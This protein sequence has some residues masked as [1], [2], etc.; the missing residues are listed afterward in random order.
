MYHFLAQYYRLNNQ[1]IWRLVSK[2]N[3][4]MSKDLRKHHQ[5]IPLLIFYLEKFLFRVYYNLATFPNTNYLPI[6]VKGTLLHGAG[7][8]KICVAKWRRADSPKPPWDKEREENGGKREGERD[9]ILSEVKDDP[10]SHNRGSPWSRLR[11]RSPAFSISCHGSSGAG[12]TEFIR[13][14]ILLPDM[15]NDMLSPRR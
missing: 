9:V 6:N 13:A 2:L 3:F 12:R 4:D 1:I 11:L 7:A 5:R 8:R 10:G 14:E 15:R